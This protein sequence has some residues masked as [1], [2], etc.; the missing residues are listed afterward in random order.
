MLGQYHNKKKNET[1]KFYYYFYHLENFGFRLVYPRLGF[2]YNITLSSEKKTLLK[3]IT[4]PKE[5]RYQNAVDDSSMNYGNIENNKY[6]THSLTSGYVRSV[7]DLFNI[8]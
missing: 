2:E 5:K 7:P 3:K 8:K 1:I 4:V 6:I